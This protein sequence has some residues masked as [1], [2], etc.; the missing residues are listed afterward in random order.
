MRAKKAM[1][2]TMASLIY[3]FV[4]I[5]CG[6]IT[7][8]LILQA[9]GSTYN[10]IISS[11]TQFLSMIS[12]LTLGIAGATRVELYKTLAQE[13]VLGTSRIIKATKHYMR[14]VA[15]AIIFYSGVL[16]LV[17][18]IISHSNLSHIEIMSLIAILSLGTFTQYFFGTAY[19]TLLMADQREYVSSLLQAVST[20]L[21]TIFTAVLVVAG[22]SI[23]VVKLASTTA[24]ALTPIILNF[25]V[26]KQYGLTNDCIADTTA[27]KNR[28]AVAFH[29]IANIIHSN[30]DLFIL[31][32]FTDAKIISVYTVY[33]LVI[34]KIKSLL[35][36]LTNGLEAAF[37][38]MWAK[39]EINSV[40]QNFRAYELAIFSFVSVVF[41]CIGVLIVPFVTE[42]TRGIT[43]VNYVRYSFAMV[44]TIAESIYCIRHPYLTLVQA[45]GSYKETKNAA[46]L[47]A[48]ANVVVSIVLVNIIGMNGVI[49]GT[50]VANGIRTA[51]YV[52]FVSKHI[53]HRDILEVFRRLMW[54][55][56]TCTIIV[57]LSLTTIGFVNS[58][59]WIG[60]IIKALATFGISC[61]I[62]VITNWIFYKDDL[63]I[64]ISVMKRM[65]ALRKTNLSRKF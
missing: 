6:L 38:N 16:M 64:L 23:F 52:W 45:T 30:V 40:R 42:Y 5:I 60:W 44:I 35:Q 28:G 17:Y 12:I 2:N 47:E 9:F 11:V 46:L 51:H 32:L 56:F 59:G 19:Q 14:K 24:F 58:I 26:H 25:Y 7:P 65:F 48:I 37:G 21:N 10:G 39:N 8:R 20:I 27:I 49:L 63:L 18:P 13:D 50:L 53:L 22:C 41:T 54:L 4:T 3:Q 29:S 34:G 61:L 55:I 43:D 33:Y 31:T 36:S 62:S 15:V 57:L 1:Y